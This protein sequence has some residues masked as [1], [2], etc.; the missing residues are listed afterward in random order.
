MKLYKDSCAGCHGLSDA[1]TDA[2]TNLYPGAPQFAR[3]PPT[4]PDWQLHAIVKY[5][6]RYSG[7]FA[8]D[9]VWGRDS[10]G[11][12]VTDGNIWTILAFLRRLDSL[13]PAVAK[14]WHAKPAP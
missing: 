9:G 6:V 11:R 10:T 4:L 7:M 1:Q 12:D 2:S 3:H 14:E 8:W 13:P 5:G